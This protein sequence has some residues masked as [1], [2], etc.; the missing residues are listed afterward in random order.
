MWV[1][2]VNGKNTH[3]ERVSSYSMGLLKECHFW[4][5]MLGFIRQKKLINQSKLID[6]AVIIFLGAYEKN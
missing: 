1:V 3:V 6:E 4:S 2:T 5:M